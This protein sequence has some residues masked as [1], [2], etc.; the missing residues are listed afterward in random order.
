MQNILMKRLFKLAEK[1][2][3]VEANAVACLHQFQYLFP[4]VLAEPKINILNP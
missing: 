1:K 4:F 3:D 2:T